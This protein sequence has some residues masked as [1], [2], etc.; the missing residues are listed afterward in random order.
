MLTVY[1][2]TRTILLLLLLTGA[3]WLISTREKVWSCVLWAVASSALYLYISMGAGYW[4]VVVTFWLVVATLVGLICSV[5]F[6]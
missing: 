1:T 4:I 3:V 5:I 6:S 2:W